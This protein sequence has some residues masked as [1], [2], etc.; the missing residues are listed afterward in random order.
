MTNHI[1]TNK[2]LYYWK[3]IYSKLCTFCNLE[4]ENIVHLFCECLYVRRFWRKVQDYIQTNI[5]LDDSMD[6]Q[7]INIIFNKVY[8]RANHLADTIII[9]AK[10]YIYRARCMSHSLDINEFIVE[11]TNM[12]KYEFYYAKKQDKLRKHCKKWSP[13]FPDLNP[14]NGDNIIQDQVTGDYIDNL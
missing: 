8:P 5:R 7:T 11:I 10:Q 3:I 2:N 1:V 12:Y 4:P 13:L 14:Q 6:F 9:A